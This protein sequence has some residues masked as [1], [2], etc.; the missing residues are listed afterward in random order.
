MPRKGYPRTKT[1]ADQKK[2][3]TLTVAGVTFT[4]DQVVYA[5]VKI[6]SRVITIDKKEEEEKTIGFTQPE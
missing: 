3:P 6:D 5:Q 1:M 2:K 4:A